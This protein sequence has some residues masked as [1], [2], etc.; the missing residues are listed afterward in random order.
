MERVYSRFIQGYVAFANANNPGRDMEKILC[1]KRDR[2]GLYGQVTKRIW[3]MP[4]RQQAMKDVAAC[5]KPRG[6]GKQASI[7]GYPNGETR[8]GEPGHRHL[9]S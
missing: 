6:A 9:N 1:N 8:P 5:E 3:W 4:W 2:L 7:R